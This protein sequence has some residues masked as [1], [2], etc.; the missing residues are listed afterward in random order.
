MFIDHNRSSTGKFEV[1]ADVR[2]S[3]GEVVH[4]QVGRNFNDVDRAVAW[5][6]KQA[7]SKGW[8]GVLVRNRSNGWQYTVVV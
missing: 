5:A 7:A 4:T 3:Y 8:T 6:A 1:M 2:G